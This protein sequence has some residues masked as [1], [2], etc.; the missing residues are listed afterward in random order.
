MNPEFPIVIC[1]AGPAGLSAAYQALKGGMR[2]LLLEGNSRIGGLART[3]DY[4]GYRFD[5]GGHR[6]FTKDERILQLW[7]EIMGNELLR[8]KRRSRIYSRG[9]F[10]EYPIEVPDALAN[11]GLGESALAF[12]SYL[13]ARLFPYPQEITFEQ[14]VVNRFGRR[15][16]EVFFRGYTEKVWGIPC[17]QIHAEWAARRI[18]GLSFA[19]AL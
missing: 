4:K 14:W 6:F 19:A 3:K 9:R 11:L 2:P 18:R 16:F 10:L 8:V 15:L 7:L 17:N 12:F 1:G 13:R 5:L